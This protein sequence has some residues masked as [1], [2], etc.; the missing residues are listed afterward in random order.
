MKGRRQRKGDC[1]L[2]WVIGEEIDLKKKIN[3]QSPSL[4]YYDLY[5]NISHVV[6]KE[7]D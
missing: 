2:S 5:L 3:L 4:L 1:K 7:S 6:S